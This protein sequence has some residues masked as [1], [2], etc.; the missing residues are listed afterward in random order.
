MFGKVSGSH[1]WTFLKKV[2]LGHHL[3]FA[4][5]WGSQNPLYNRFLR[6][7][8]SMGD[9]FQK[10]RVNFTFCVWSYL[11]LVSGGPHELRLSLSSIFSNVRTDIFKKRGQNLRIKR[12]C[13]LC[14]HSHYG[15]MFQSTQ[16]RASKNKVY[17]RTHLCLH[18]FQVFLTT[19]WQQFFVVLSY[20]HFHYLNPKMN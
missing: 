15:E 11:Q 1:Y 12:V 14:T 9:A 2:C 7:S 18:I 6:V 4:D 16:N 19:S 5:S 13:G 10:L 17:H 3:G 20:P 8:C